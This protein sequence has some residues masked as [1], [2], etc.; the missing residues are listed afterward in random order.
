M[1]DTFE[2]VGECSGANSKEIMKDH[3][4]RMFR[5]LLMTDVIIGMYYLCVLKLSPDYDNRELGIGGG[6]LVKA[7]SR[8]CGRTEK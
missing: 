3:L 5:P 8:V 6:I 7:I 2:A 1:C 4:S